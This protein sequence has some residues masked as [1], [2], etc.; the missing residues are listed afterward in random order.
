MQVREAMTEL[1]LPASQE[2]QPT[3]LPPVKEYIPT[4]QHVIDTLSPVYS[5]VCGKYIPTSSL[6]SENAEL[7]IRATLLQWNLTV[8]KELQ[9]LNALLSMK[10]TLLGMITFFRR[11][12][13]NELTPISSTVGGI[14][15]ASKL[16]SLK[17]EA[18]N[19]TN[20]ELGANVILKDPDVHDSNALVPKLVTLD[21]MVRG[22]RD[23]QD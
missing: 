5:T 19:V 20:L 21:G 4:G 3:S 9:L 8:C 16:E 23:V 15:I 11:V 22:P 7:L 17:A 1:N 10:V 2:V 14:T 6:Q 12:D 18:S 13:S